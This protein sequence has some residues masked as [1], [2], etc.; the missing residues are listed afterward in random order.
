MGENSGVVGTELDV[1]ARIVITGFEG[2]TVGGGSGGKAAWVD[3]TKRVF[4]TARR[5]LPT[6][7]YCSLGRTQSSQ[8]RCIVNG[9]LLQFVTVQPP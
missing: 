3:V 5:Y 2:S 9:G 4:S 1:D 7:L 8:R 6:D